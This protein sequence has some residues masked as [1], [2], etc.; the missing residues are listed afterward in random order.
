MLIH[1]RL[2]EALLGPYSSHVELVFSQTLPGAKGTRRFW[3][4]SGEAMLGPYSGHA[5]L[6]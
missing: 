3:I 6:C 1:V 5:E 2:L 4:M